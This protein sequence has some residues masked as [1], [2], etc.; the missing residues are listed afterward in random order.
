MRIEEDGVFGTTTTAK[1]LLRLSLI[2]LMAG[3]V[4]LCC[5]EVVLQILNPGPFGTVVEEQD[6]QYIVRT[7]GP[8]SEVVATLP[9]E[10]Y[11]QMCIWEGVVKV[12]MVLFGSGLALHILSRLL[13]MRKSLPVAKK[14]S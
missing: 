6:G 9:E 13:L 10:T 12:G 8:G 5:A 14:V 7:R 11:R 4:V 2:L 1:K 3:A